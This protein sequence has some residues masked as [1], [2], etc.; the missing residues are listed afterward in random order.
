MSNQPFPDDEPIGG[1][2]DPSDQASNLNASGGSSTFVYGGGFMGFQIT[3]DCS[4]F[5][6]QVP[7]DLDARD[8]NGSSNVVYSYGASPHSA[9]FKRYMYDANDHPMNHEITDPA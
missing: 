1:F 9:P 6:E 4:T 5:S 8:G 3:V 2:T 7:K